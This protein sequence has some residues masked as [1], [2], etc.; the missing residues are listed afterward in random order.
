LDGLK[1]TTKH[2]QEKQT[3]IPGSKQLLPGVRQALE[4]YFLN[5]Q[6]CGEEVRDYQDSHHP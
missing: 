3:H 1:K 2:G 4:R 5:R 6:H